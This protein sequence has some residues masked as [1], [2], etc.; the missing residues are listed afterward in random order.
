VRYTWE[1]RIAGKHLPTAV[2]VQW[3]GCSIGCLDFLNVVAGDNTT[4]DESDPE[5][6][7]VSLNKGFTFSDD[8]W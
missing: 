4:T 3:R 5:L 8:E 6:V 1:L 7:P 2:P